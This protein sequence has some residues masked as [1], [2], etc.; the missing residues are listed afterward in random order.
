M[1]KEKSRAK[2]IRETEP[3]PKQPEQICPTC[4]RPYYYY[5]QYS[6]YP[7]PPPVPPRRDRKSDRTIILVVV[8]VFI[9]FF[10]IFLGFMVMLFSS[11]EPQTN[12]RDFETEVIISEGGHFKYYLDDIYD[13]DLEVELDITSEDGKYFDVYIMELSQYELIYNN[14][15][16]SF[17]SFSSYYSLEN[18]SRVDD[19]IKLNEEYG[20]FYLVIDN[21]DNPLTVSDAIPQGTITLDLKVTISITYVWD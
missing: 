21:T 1:I 15:N 20:T 6:P 12:K 7:T 4:N 9:I 16:E 8:A 11:F 17:I 18:V 19:T 5:P 2:S 14:E 13:D 3:Q 10:I